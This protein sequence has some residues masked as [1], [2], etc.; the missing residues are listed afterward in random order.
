MHSF[1]WPLY[2]EK[3]VLIV[4]FDRLAIMAGGIDPSLNSCQEVVEEV[5]GDEIY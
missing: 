5:F 1:S 2:A 4:H 3:V